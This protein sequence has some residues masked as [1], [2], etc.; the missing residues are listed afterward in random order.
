MRSA[1]QRQPAC[2]HDPAINLHLIG[3]LRRKNSPL[4]RIFSR[5]RG[6]FWCGNSLYPGRV[7]TPYRTL[8]PLSYNST[9]ALFSQ[10]VT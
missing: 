2:R 5:R 6:T 7:G 9:M 4:S 3:A 8:A 1:R 10:Y